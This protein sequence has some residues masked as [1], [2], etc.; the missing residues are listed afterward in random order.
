[1]SARNTQQKRWRA[2]RG[3][4][5]GKLERQ[6]ALPAILVSLNPMPKT[7]CE[8]TKRDLEKHTD[9]FYELVRNPRYYCNKCACVANTSKVLCKP[10]PF[11]KAILES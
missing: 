4:S 5:F 3:G 8:W 1:M 6:L 9:K 2:G 11:P 7:L 10:H